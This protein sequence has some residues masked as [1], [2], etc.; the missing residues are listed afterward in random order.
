MKKP[1]WLLCLLLAGCI[2]FCLLAGCAGLRALPDA[3]SQAADSAQ[4]AGL[5]EE[6]PESRPAGSV[7][8]TAPGEEGPESQAASSAQSAAPD[9]QGPASAGGQPLTEEEQAWWLR[10]AELLAK[11]L[12]EYSF[13]QDQLG[14]RREQLDPLVLERFANSMSFLPAELDEAYLLAAEPE[15]TA[16]GTTCRLPYDRLCEVLRHC[17]GWSDDEIAK[18][19][20][21]HH[22][23]AENCL[24]VPLEV[25]RYGYFSI[26]EMD[27]AFAE[28]DTIQLYL[29]LWGG[30]GWPDPVDHGRHCLTL[31][32]KEEDGQPFLQFESLLAEGPE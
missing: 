30:L 14:S 5:G 17:F 2:G 3:E 8:S 6:S 13:S 11:R 28:E 15:F 27:A 1:V 7:Q 16:D 29:T 22:D 26:T 18:I 10:Q 19:E 23:P 31:R 4:S 12:V 32:L 21:D 20:F 24:V 25:G 9:A